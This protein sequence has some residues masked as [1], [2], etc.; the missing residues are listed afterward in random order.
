MIMYHYVI[1]GGGQLLP[2]FRCISVRI[3][4]TSAYRLL[5]FVYKE[6]GNKKFPVLRDEKNKQISWNKTLILG[7]KEDIPDKK[8]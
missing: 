2:P 8:A 6:V 4:E 5:I 7:W 3:E 1:G